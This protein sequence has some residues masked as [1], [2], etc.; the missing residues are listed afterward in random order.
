[1]KQEVGDGLTMPDT[2]NING[3]NS[4]KTTSLARTEFSVE[5]LKI[6]FPESDLRAHVGFPIRRK[7]RD[8]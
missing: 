2:H 3:I 6:T 7:N 1:M 8:A 5:K 4:I